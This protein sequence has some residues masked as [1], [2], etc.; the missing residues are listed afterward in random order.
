MHPPILTSQL[1]GM[2]ILKYHDR[3]LDSTYNGSFSR[4]IYSIIFSQWSGMLDL[5]FDALNPHLSSLGLSSVRIDGRSTL[6]QRR[7]AVD[8][9][10]GDGGC[11]IMLATIG[12]V[13]EGYVLL[14]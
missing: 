7:H 8:K 11:R 1:K 14:S 13:G 12:A 4:A 3:T 6:Q 2:S 5:I 9:F 10:Y